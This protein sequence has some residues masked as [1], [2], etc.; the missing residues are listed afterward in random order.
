MRILE[1]TNTCLQTLSQ[2]HY[3]HTHHYHCLPH[4]LWL[5]GNTSGIIDNPMFP[6]SVTQQSGAMVITYFISIRIDCLFPILWEAVSCNKC[7]VIVSPTI[8][9]DVIAS[10]SPHQEVPLSFEQSSSMA[11]D[12]PSRSK[13]PQPYSPRDEIPSVDTQLSGKA[14]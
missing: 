11:F 9:I 7:R 8:L 12:H 3:R 14:P 5:Y 2:N 1:S 4:C 10:N 13:S 6:R